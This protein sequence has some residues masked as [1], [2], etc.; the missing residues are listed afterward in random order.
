MHIRKDLN[1]ANTQSRKIKPIRYPV[2]III[3]LLLCVSVFYFFEDHINNRREI[4]PEEPDWIRRQFLPVNDYSRPAI[5]L[6]AIKG[7]VVHYVANPGT[8]ASNNRSYFE[9]LANSGATHASSH[10][11]IGLEGEVI[12]C[13]PLNEVAFASNERNR[14]TISIELC[15][16]D[17][18]GRPAD[19]TYASLVRLVKWLC[20][21]YKLDSGKVI[22]HYD[23]TGKMC[24]KYYVDHPDDWES[25]LEQI[26]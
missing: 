20:E 12:Q 1:V 26:K 23:V 19:E 9:G 7:V 24:P 11:I 17:E 18:S 25:F 21:T 5:E 10:F 16:P 14:D 13:I 4:Q 2:L 6:K 3:F 8:S 15:H 22:R